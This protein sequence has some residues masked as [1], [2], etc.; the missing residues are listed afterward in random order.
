MSARMRLRRADGQIYLDRWGIEHKRVGGVFLHR[1]DAADPGRDL[2]DHPWWFVS[3]IVA[4][5]YV[6]QR[7]D[8]R[9]APAYAR[10]AD[11]WPGCEPGY[12]VE[13]RR[14][15]WKTMR[16]DECHTITR[17]HRRRS[18]SLVIHGPTRRRWGFYLA[19]GWMLWTRYDEQVR[20]RDLVA[21]I[22][23][24]R[25]PRVANR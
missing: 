21:E 22:S 19:D 18:W 7:A 10:L 13:R 11:A 6:E 25:D 16:L 3:F 20:G 12:P 15:S 4:G 9:N 17:L 23:S 5:G 14:W 24:N 1:M 8:T 2:H